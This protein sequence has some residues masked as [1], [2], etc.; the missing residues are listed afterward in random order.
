M[1]LAEGV[2][3]RKGAAAAQNR[4]EADHFV[5]IGNAAKCQNSLTCKNGAI[6]RFSF[7]TETGFCECKENG[8]NGVL[9]T[10]LSTRRREDI[11]EPNSFR[12]QGN[13][14]TRLA[15]SSPQELQTTTG[16]ACRRKRQTE[17]GGVPTKHSL[18]VCA[19]RGIRRRAQRRPHR[20]TSP[21]SKRGHHLIRQDR[22]RHRASSDRNFRSLLRLGK[23][24]I[25]CQA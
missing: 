5:N 17:A 24:T 16:V 7:G 14:W 9:T 3:R 6:C 1:F 2:L 13:L 15:T 18:C 10:P 19:R 8:T 11:V 25:D 23:E 20:S 21:T 12:S 4:Y 22:R